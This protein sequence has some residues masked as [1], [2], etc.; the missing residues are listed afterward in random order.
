MSLGSL[1]P[2]KPQPNLQKFF[3]SFFQKRRLCFGFSSAG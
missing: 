3:A 1:Y 2:E